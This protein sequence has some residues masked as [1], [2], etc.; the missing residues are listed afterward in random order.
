[1]LYH[2]DNLNKLSGVIHTKQLVNTSN[3]RHNKERRPFLSY[4]SYL[5]VLASKPPWRVI[6]VLLLLINYNL[7]Y[8][9]IG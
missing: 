8:F 2:Q 4:L 7:F 9:P 5:I 6:L 3:V 1:M